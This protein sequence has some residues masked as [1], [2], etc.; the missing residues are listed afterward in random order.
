MKKKPVIV[1]KDFLEELIG[2]FG[3]IHKLPEWQKLVEEDGWYVWLTHPK[4]YGPELYKDLKTFPDD[5]W[6]EHG[7][8]LM[9]RG[10]PAFNTNTA[11]WGLCDCG[12]WGEARDN[13]LKKLGLPDFNYEEE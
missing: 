9:K 3:G 7:G 5:W 1:N 12:D 10:Y 11:E 8:L 13:V 2:A 4:Q 6:A